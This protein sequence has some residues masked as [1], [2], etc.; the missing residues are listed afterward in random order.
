[1]LL[2][3]TMMVQ[4]NVY[5]C[6]ITTGFSCMEGKY[7]TKTFTSM[8]PTPPPYFGHCKQYDPKIANNHESFEKYSISFSF[9]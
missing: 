2:F 7:P 6:L 9:E 3:L 4:V 1:M 5:V 8:V